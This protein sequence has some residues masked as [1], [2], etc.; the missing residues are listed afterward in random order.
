MEPVYRSLEVIAGTL[1][2]AQGVRRRYFGLENIPGTGGFVLALNHNGFTDFLSPALGLYR[3]G[4]RGRFMVK[5]ELMDIP[6]M[7]F[8]INHTKTVPVD[9]SAGAQAFALAAAELRDGE[10]IV[11]YP[12]TTISRSFELKEFKTG[13]VRMAADA[14]VPVLP[15]IQ[16]GAQRQWSKGTRRRMGYARIGVDV[17]FGEPIWFPADVDVHAGTDE[18]HAAME[19]LLHQVQDGYPEAPAG[20]DWLPARLGGSAPVPEEALVIEDAEAAE[21]ARRRA[22]KGEDEH[23]GRR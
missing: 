16:W 1:V 7:R 15:A 2:R 20:A 5:S 6:I 10:V 12:E 18:L 9:R 4:R 14:G 19:G 8:L 17:R 3:R 13:A 21:K 23:N 11:V 22:A